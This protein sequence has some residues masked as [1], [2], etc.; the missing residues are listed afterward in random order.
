MRESAIRNLATTPADLHDFPALR[1]RLGS[2]RHRQA[3]AERGWDIE[4]RHGRCASCHEVADLTYLDLCPSCFKL[5]DAGE[6]AQEANGQWMVRMFR[7]MCFQVLELPLPAELHPETA[8]F[9]RRFA[10]ALAVKLRRAEI[11]YGL[12][13]GWADPGRGDELRAKLD[14]HM[15]KGD[16][17]DVAIFAGFLW[18]HRE[19]TQKAGETPLPEW[20]A[21]IRGFAVCASLVC[22]L[23]GSLNPHEVFTE[24]GI[25]WEDLRKAGCDNFDMKR[26]ARELGREGLLTIGRIPL[27]ERRKAG[28]A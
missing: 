18:H 26:I 3:A 11:K 19:R 13:A 14:E 4:L 2:E 7:A 17:L 27:S 23:G 9:V 25:T 1:A 16:P 5:A 20:H 28:E 12:A 8:A 15:R 21:F 22:S 24:N 10:V 6:I